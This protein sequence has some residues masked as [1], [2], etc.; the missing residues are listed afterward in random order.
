MGVFANR[1]AELMAVVE[2][3]ALNVKP[4]RIPGWL[5]APVEALGARCPTT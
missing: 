5:A 3:M 1:L 4:E 2:E